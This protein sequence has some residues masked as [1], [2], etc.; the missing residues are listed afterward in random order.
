VIHEY[1]KQVADPHGRLYTVRAHGGPRLDG[2]WEGWL[3]FTGPDGAA[4]RTGRET[5]QSNREA[6]AY[7]AAGL[8]PIYLDGARARARPVS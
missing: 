4:L 5:T 7:W 2:L 8:E 6:L 3:S 1:V